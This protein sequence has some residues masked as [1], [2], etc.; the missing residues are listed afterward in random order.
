[1]WKNTYSQAKEAKESEGQNGALHILTCT[2]G[3]TPASIDTTDYAR[4][5]AGLVQGELHSLPLRR[6]NSATAAT[7]AFIEH[8]SPR[9]D[10]I[11]L[12]G[13]E[14][15]SLPSTETIALT[16]SQNYS[17]SLLAVRTPVWPLQRIL[18]LVRGEATDTATIEWGLRLAQASN[19][20]VTLLVVLP[21]SV[22]GNGRFACAMSDLLAGH[23][24]PGKY[25]RQ[26]LKQLADADV[27]TTLKLN[28][29]SPERQVRQEVMEEPYDL[30]IVSAEPPG[31]LLRKRLEPLI[32]P[33]LT[34]TER[35]V[36]IARPLQTE[37]ETVALAK[38]DSRCN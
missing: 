13:S 38:G 26:V 4:Q 12:G 15:A 22:S 28:Q 18:L 27:N 7:V 25:V 5:L 30:I 37:R 31:R 6:E 29:G 16:T 32:A 34:W 9:Y 24:L 11:V 23:S 10:M 36:L 2:W 14:E 1:M 8:V 3:N 35:P 33:L 21:A 17:S 19:S 20:A